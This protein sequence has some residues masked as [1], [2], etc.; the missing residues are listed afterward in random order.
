MK[1]ISRLAAIALERFHLEQVT[2]RLIIAEEQNRIANEMRQRCTGLFSI[3][4]TIHSL[5][6]NG[7]RMSGSQLQ[8]SLRLL[9]KSL[10][11]QWK[12]CV[13]PY[14][15]SVQKREAENHLNRA[16]PNILI[17]FPN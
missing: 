13:P 14:I 2:E 5:I 10:N 7:D 3:S 6:Q 15:G 11:C 9:Q 4:Y 12:S 16:S 1:F 8:E 17:Q